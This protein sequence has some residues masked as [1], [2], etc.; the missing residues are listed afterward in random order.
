LQ[1]GDSIYIFSDGYTDQF[2]G[3]KGKK[4]KNK[5]FEDKLLA[6][7]S[8]SMSEQKKILEET[9]LS[10]KGSLEQIDDILI[11]GVRISNN[12]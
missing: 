11:I 9:F 3:E 8:R 5:Q 7:Q 4:F 6:I 12:E 1:R 10:W 2:G